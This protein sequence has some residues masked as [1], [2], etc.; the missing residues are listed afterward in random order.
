MISSSLGS[1][2]SGL[3]ENRSW[4]MGFPDVMQGCGY[5]ESLYVRTGETD[6]H[7]EADRHSRHQHAMLERSFMIARTSSS[8]A[9]SPFCSMLL[10]IL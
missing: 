8:H 1:R 9:L 10:M 6:I 4:N 2:A 7:G 5:S 3:V